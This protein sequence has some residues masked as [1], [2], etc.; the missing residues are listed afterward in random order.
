[1]EKKVQNKRV[2]RTLALLEQS[3]AELMKEKKPDAITVKELTQH[4]NLNRGTFY[5]HYKDID[6]LLE[7][8]VSG[9]I[10]TLLEIIRTNYPPDSSSSYY[11][12][13]LEVLRY[14]KENQ[15]VC[16]TI[17]LNP[18]S[19][20]MQ[21]FRQEL[22]HREESELESYYGKDNIPEY[23]YFLTFATTGAIGVMEQWM[24][25]TH[26]ST[27]ETIAK[28]LDDFVCGGR[29]SLFGRTSISHIYTTAYHPMR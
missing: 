22:K 1:M 12:M 28:M 13:F 2:K 6:D 4:A 8:V 5:L 3:L 26:E 14:L 16:L 10:D 27:L 29:A 25:N 7:Q 19:P 17:F 23:N 24:N 9:K 18:S 11:H 21:R 15:N 20:A